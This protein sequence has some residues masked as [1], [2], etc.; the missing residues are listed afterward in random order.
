MT[1]T[2]VNIATN[3]PVTITGSALTAGQAAQSGSSMPEISA[4][5]RGRRVG[6][7]ARLARSTWRVTTC[8]RG[9]AVDRRAM[10]QYPQSNDYRPGTWKGLHTPFG[11]KA[12]FTC[13]DCGQTGSLADHSIHDDGRVDPS[14]V[15]PYDCTFHE[16]IVLE[17]WSGSQ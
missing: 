6:A 13:P 14:V 4:W 16:F 2:N 11:R 10:K 8:V 15:C 9:C 3:Q 5:S 17:G 7:V 12:S 1:L